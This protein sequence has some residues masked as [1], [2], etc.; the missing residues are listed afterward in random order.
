MFHIL[1]VINKKFKALILL[2]AVFNKVTIQC[3]EFKIVLIRIFEFLQLV[4]E[5]NKYLLFKLEYTI[6]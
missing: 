6:K 5:I 1:H 4:N 3:T 2:L